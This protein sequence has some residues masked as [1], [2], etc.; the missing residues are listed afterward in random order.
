MAFPSAVNNV[1]L[2]KGI[3]AWRQKVEMQLL[4]AGW[5]NDLEKNDAEE[6]P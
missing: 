4:P 6:R 5:K 1:K 2:T 3:L